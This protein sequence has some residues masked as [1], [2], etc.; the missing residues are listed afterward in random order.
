MADGQNLPAHYRPAAQAP[1]PFE[2]Q[3]RM[4]ETFAA[5]GL[6]GVKTK[7]QALALILI[8]E[9]EGMAPALAVQEFDIIEGKPARKAE[10]IQARFQLCGGKITWLTYENDCV[11]AKFEHPQGS[12]VTIKWTLE[13]ASRVTFYKKDRD[14]GGKWVKLTDKYNWK[15]YPRAM[16]RSRVIAEGARACYP[17]Y[18]VV[19]LC[20]DEAI[21]MGS[22]DSEAIMDDVIDQT[23]EHDESTPAQPSPE[24]DKSQPFL[25]GAKADKAL[26]EAIASM[27]SAAD[28]QKLDAIWEDARRLNVSQNRQFGLHEA[29]EKNKARLDGPTI[30]AKPAPTST[31]LFEELKTEAL[32][33]LDMPKMFTD[34]EDAFAGWANKL[35]AQ[36]LG[37]MTKAQ[38]DELQQVYRNLKAE[39]DGE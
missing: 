31:D 9:A 35:D 33:I 25:K 32:G 39:I 22:V 19:T 16:L 7:P 34:R 38:R 15:S 20:V 24:P 2:Q 12:T 10:R 1:I 29:Y 6:F 11:E 30:E 36:T 13:D 37:A 5:S 4:A 27:D 23:P 17:A 8:G 28:Q 3:E 14:G 26:E 21:D 18:A